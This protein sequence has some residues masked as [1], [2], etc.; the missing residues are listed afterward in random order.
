MSRNADVYA[1][2]SFR[3]TI[4]T[5]GAVKVGPFP[6][7]LATSIKLVSGGTLE[8]GAWG[9][10]LPY[11]AAFGSSTVQAFTGLTGG[12]AVGASQVPTQMYF[13]STNEV[14]SVNN[15]GAFVLYATGGTCVVAIA[16]GRSAN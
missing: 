3:V 14:F 1:I 5:G 8:I 13:L 7:Q 15:S 2:P 16:S 4:G 10:S 11:E 9:A 12:Y 6:G